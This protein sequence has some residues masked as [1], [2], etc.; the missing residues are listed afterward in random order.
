MSP[1]WPSLSIKYL[2]NDYPA[3]KWLLRPTH[4]WGGEGVRWAC[5][6]NRFYCAIF[7]KFF[8]SFMIIY[9]IRIKK[10]YCLLNLKIAKVGFEA[11]KDI[12][13]KFIAI[14]C[15]FPETFVF[16]NIKRRE[17]SKLK[18]T[19]MKVL[20]YFLKVQYTFFVPL[21]ETKTVSRL[22]SEE[23]FKLISS[24]ELYQI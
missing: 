18:N 7:E 15:N 24:L 20:N 11:L 16:L 17:G 23:I 10:R 1:C 22:K 19:A 12:F 2:T 5:P 9:K 3:L 14:T 8:I 13:G 4:G 21:N 6:H